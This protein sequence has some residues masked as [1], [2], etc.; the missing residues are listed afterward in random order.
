MYQDVDE[1][2]AKGT[3]SE[4]ASGSGNSS[5]LALSSFPFGT[6]AGADVKPLQQNE[7]FG[8]ERKIN[9]DISLKAR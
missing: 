2:N 6:V 4:K 1:E 5:K 7:T 9:G 8:I 3:A